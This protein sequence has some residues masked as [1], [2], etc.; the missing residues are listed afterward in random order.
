MAKSSKKEWWE[1]VFGEEYLKTYVDSI[2]PAKTKAQVDFIVKNLK[3]R[4]GV[5]ILDLACGQGRHSIELA[6]RGYKV[7]G[8]DFSKYLINIAKENAKKKRMAADFIQG[9]MRNLYFRNK[10]DAIINIFT[11]FGY[12]DKEEDNIKVIKKI[13]RALKPRGKFLVDL[14]NPINL[15]VQLTPDKQAERKGLLKSVI[16]DFFNGIRIT[17]S[18]EF[19]P[20]TM[21]WS[22][23]RE[24]KEKGKKRAYTFNMRSFTL[25]ELKHLFKEN[26]LVVERVWGDFQGSSSQILRGK[27][28]E[29]KPYCFDSPR[30]IVLARKLSN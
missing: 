24:W 23:R 4:K 25:P 20:E 29:D 2:T 8:L 16:K 15:L 3:L 19:N 17:T 30:M 18:S 21:V 27:I 26:G 13:S 7:T 12:F 6:K 10:F 11:S 28:R 5:S 14:A 9:D 1:G 22:M